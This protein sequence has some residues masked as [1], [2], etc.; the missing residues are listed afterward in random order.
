MQTNKGRGRAIQEQHKMPDAVIL[1]IM[2]YFRLQHYTS[3]FRFTAGQI[4]RGERTAVVG[5]ISR[6]MKGAID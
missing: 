3:A 2:K 5:T 4:R 6:I 1:N